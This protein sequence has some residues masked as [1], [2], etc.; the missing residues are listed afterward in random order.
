MNKN[1]IYVGID[2]SLKTLVTCIIDTSGAILLKPT[3]FGNN[4]NSFELLTNKII[5][6][7]KEM[8][9][10]FILFGCESTS[11]YDNHL[12]YSIYD[13]EALNKFNCRIHAF[14]P[15]LILNFKKS[16]GD[17]PKN[18]KSDSYV[19][20]CR[21]KAGSLPNESYINF[22]QI[23]LQRLTRFR[24]H[25]AKNITREKT[26]LV[27]N[28]FLKFSTLFQSKI[29]SDNYGATA[30]ALLT[31]FV[32]IEDIASTPIEELVDIIRIKGRDHFK[33]IDSVANS[34]KNAASNSFKLN[35]NLNDSLSFVIK[36]TFDSISAMEKSL[37][38]TDKEIEKQI[39]LYFNN[40]YTVLTS[41]KGIG[42]V[43]AGGIIAEIGSIKRFN[44]DNALAKFSGIVWSQY[45]SGEYQAS[46][47]K[48]R[49][50]GNSYLRYYFCLA[51]DNLRLYNPIFQTYYSGKYREV[52]DHFHKRALVLT[53][54]KVIRL[55]FS[56]LQENR[57]YIQDTERGN[58]NDN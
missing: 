45:Q 41:L 19:I 57:L 46:N 33:D 20:A 5:S 1:Y 54:R 22:K 11:V 26:Y 44:S 24:F 56:L 50:T 21:L 18:D 39:K 32:N 48:L 15:D 52:K 42:P 49:K 28:L 29:L 36:S 9:N 37:K 6:F 8:D 3:S 34:I 27:S 47:T 12:Q 31:E 38:Y 2:V 16:M 35:K 7:A 58:A 53:A 25:I 4:P 13:S 55:V 30:E 14:K 10:P 51:A 40:E 23:A 17:L 43:I